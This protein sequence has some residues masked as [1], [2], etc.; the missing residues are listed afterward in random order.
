MNRVVA[1][2]VLAL[3]PFTLSC[4]AE[5]RAKKDSFE[6]WTRYYEARMALNSATSIRFGPAPEDACGYVVLEA[7]FGKSGLEYVLTTYYNP[8]KKDCRGPQDIAL[9]EACHRRMQHHIAG[10]QLENMG[11]SA[12][13]EARE[14]EKWYRARK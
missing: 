5:E 8:R 12:E 14:C 7:E 11:V 9:H 1:A 6:Y 2:L 13:D 10:R 3:S 4:L